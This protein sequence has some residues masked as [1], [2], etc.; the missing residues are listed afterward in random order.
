M[1]SETMTSISKNRIV[2][3]SGGGVEMMLIYAPSN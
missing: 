3:S 2:T 1:S